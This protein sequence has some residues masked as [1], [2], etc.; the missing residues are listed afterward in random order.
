MKLRADLRAFRRFC[1]DHG[2][3]KLQIGIPMLGRRIVQCTREGERG[4]NIE[5]VLESPP[6][7]VTSLGELI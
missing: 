4:Q 2:E 7:I 5:G 3:E 1:T 6:S